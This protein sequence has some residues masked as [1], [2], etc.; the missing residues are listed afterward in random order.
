MPELPP[1]WPTNDD[2]TPYTVNEL[3]QYA[4]A[5]LTP[6]EIAEAFK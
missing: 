4:L 3:I 5:W 2:G 6:E 1:E